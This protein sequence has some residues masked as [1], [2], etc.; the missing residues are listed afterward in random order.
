MLVWECQNKEV[1]AWKADAIDYSKLKGYMQSVEQVECKHILPT[2][3]KF[4][5]RVVCQREDELIEIG[6]RNMAE[7]MAV[8]RGITTN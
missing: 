4:N 1:F 7:A 8:S 6:R 5:R 3:L 2:N